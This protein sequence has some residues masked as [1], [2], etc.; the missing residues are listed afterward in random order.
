MDYIS[1]KCI[2]RLIKLVSATGVVTLSISNLKQHF[3]KLLKEHIKNAQVRQLDLA[4]ALDLSPSAVSQII[5]GRMS[6]NLKQLDIIMQLLA[7]D[8]SACAELRDCLTRIRSGDEE[9]RSPLNDF[10]KSARTKQ[11]LTLEQLALMS[12]IPEENLQ[13]LESCVN[14]QP[15]PYEAVRLAA[16]FNCNVGELWQVIP[17]RTY[18]RNDIA[19][20]R[21]RSSTTYQPGDPSAIK[22]PVVKFSDLK[23][24][25]RHNDSLLDFA[26]RHM[27]EYRT[28]GQAGIV[29]IKA[30]GVEFGWSDLYEVELEVAETS[31]WMPGMTVLCSLDGELVLARAC[32]EYRQ[33][34]VVGEDEELF[35]Q[36]YWL[37]NAF[38]FN[39]DLWS[40]INQQRSSRKTVRNA[41]VLRPAKKESDQQ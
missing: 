41:A 31:Q 26:W 27:V 38:K 1:E 14:V 30:P 4:E 11:G 3:G 20:L 6:P 34:A 36:W 8:R 16:I 9:L 28:G 17:D 29:G 19:V 23:N 10:I 2:L 7:L 5:S 24:Y 22:T 39:S 35:C 13:M 15:T 21:E 32:S 33:V 18:E 25:D 12:G 40:A 37:V